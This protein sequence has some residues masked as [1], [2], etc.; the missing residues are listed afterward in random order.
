[1]LDKN[2]IIS[3]K[4]PVEPDICGIYFL[5]KNNQ[6]VY[7]GQSVNVKHRLYA[8]KQYKDFDYYYV[9]ECS[10][11]ELDTL[12]AQ[13]IVQFDPPGNGPI[14][15]KN[16]LYK[17]ITQIKELFGFTT[18]EINKLLKNS[19]IEPIYKNY[20]LTK[21]ILEA[22]RHLLPSVGNRQIRYK[23]KRVH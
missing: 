4:I 17:T 16:E 12:E 9:H 2:T 14:L 8:H 1:V 21:D 10:P 18:R 19:G 20:Y 11:E 22:Q 15:P 5:I 3:N 7:I 13:H 6:I 23:A